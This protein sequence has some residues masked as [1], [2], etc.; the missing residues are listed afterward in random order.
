MSEMITMFMA[1]AF[2]LA[3]CTR[4]WAQ[5]GTYCESFEDG[6]PDTFTAT[7]SA[8]LSISPWHYKQGSNSLQ[9][10]WSRGEELVI[11]QGIG[12][13]ARTGGHRCRAGFSVWLYVEEPLSDTLV[14]E[15][16]EGEKVTGFF[17]FPMAFT[18]WRQARPYYHD[19]PHGEPTA[20]V[21]NIRIAAPSAAAKGTVF[22]DFIKYNTL[23]YG[24][25][26]VIP[27]KEAQWQP[28]VPDEGRFPRP[29]RV[30]EAERAGIRKLLGPD[31]GPG[32]EQ[33]RVN[34]L[35]ERVEALGI[36][37]D[38]HGVRG[39]GIDA[40]YQFYPSGE[41]Q[42]ELG[43]GYW[44]D[45]HGP[46]W[47]GMQ[48][49]ASMSS[50]AHQVAGAYRAS[51]EAE[52]RRRLAEA[53]LLIADHLHDQAL[54]AGSG[55]KWNWWVGGAWADAVF[56][57]RD[58][59]AEAGRLQR[60]LDFLL[61]T[62]G[63][64]AIFAEGDAPSHMDFYHLTV[65]CLFRQCLMQVEEAEQVRWLNAFKAMLERSMLQPTSELKIDGSAYHHS[66]HYHSYARNAF[67]TLPPLLQEL[68]GTLWRLSAEAHE[69]LRRAML[70]QRI[71]CNRLDLPL[72]QSG[73]SPFRP[74]Y[75]FINPRAL[76]GLEA[77]AH[78][79]TPDG[80]QEIDP[81][82]AAAYLRLVPEAV[83]N[84]PYRSLG[85]EP[86][87]EPNG[88]FVLPYAAL[89]SHRRDTWLA[90][91][92][93]QSTYVWGSERQDHHN[94]FGLFQGLGHLEILAGG[95]PVSA[96]ASGREHFGW[97]W[98][99]FEGTSVP[100]LPLAVMDEGWRSGGRAYSAETFAGGLSHKGHQGMFAMILNQP[101]P[102]NKTL[103]GRKSWFFSDEQVLCMGS[104]ISCD[105][106]QHPTQTT[107]C[108]KA[109]RTN[110]GG[111]FLSTL[112]DG[113]DF[114]GFPEERTLDEMNPHWFLDVQQ[115]G[116]YLPAGQR[117]TVAREHQASRDSWDEEDTEGDFL[118]AWMDHGKA[119]NNA[120]YEYMLVIRATPEA[121]QRFAAEPPYRV[122]QRD[123]ATH[124]VWHTAAGRWS[125]VF[126]VPQEV[127]PHT[128]ATETLPIKAVDRPCLIM[129][130]A[131]R[132]GQLHISVADPDLNLEEGVNKPQP[133]RVTLRG[134]WRLLEATGTVCTW[135]LPD[136]RE[137]VRILSAG[138]AETVLEIL[139]RHGASYDVSLAC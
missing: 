121:M 7:R 124:I 93:G 118:T 110:E 71:Y 70:A 95:T 83:N 64:G 5:Q 66:G 1:F 44:S 130:E 103:T 90:S 12:D 119:P 92:H 4:A 125:C 131:L 46:D 94:R 120:S 104:D 126:F 102:E 65:P 128:A 135:H 106:A 56:L 76:E 127:T 27:E 30:T 60:H 79:G 21:D 113:T 67:G 45:E 20:E 25:N 17:R 63:G 18:G 82:V 91:V 8:S 10:D 14:F 111:E 105:E 138:A 133:L 87:P 137:N 73:R 72:S 80:K 88:T 59:L 40:Y 58:M 29:E 34:D 31:R 42:A 53:F 115:T 49:P 19:F 136:A 55:F 52:Q 129:A 84:E 33:V 123:R 38:E 85:I 48:T 51:N 68:N 100:Q 112:V 11:R 3:A 117:V 39:P 132:D 47:L 77:L 2:V 28:P 81:E 108:Q 54:Q 116:Y 98:R 74:G 69:R 41:E 61:Y 13:I 97:D 114:T 16:R 134:A 26:S 62:Y 37:R 23:T 24:G 15:F 78:C 36:V 57:M 50:L 99:R 22:L 86:E 75:G 35:C 122:I 43:S 9:W 89:L 6:V 109:L 139:C 101:M 107:L 32:I 96:K